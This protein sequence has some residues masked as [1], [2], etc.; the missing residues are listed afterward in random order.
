MTL[1]DV[2][3][4]VRRELEA[5]AKK[6]PDWPTDPLHALAVLG[7]EYGEL[8]KALLQLTY[9]PHKTTLD[10]ARAEAVQTAAMAL[11]LIQ[12]LD[13]YEFK[14][15][16][17]HRQTQRRISFLRGNHTGKS[18]ASLDEAIDWFTNAKELEY[19]VHGIEMLSV[20]GE[21]AHRPPSLTDDEFTLCAIAFFEKHRDVQA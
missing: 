14:P 4:R 13:Q 20:D 19:D 17:Q 9:E 8:N 2:I 6:Y 18:F 10:E 16:P 7:E 21:N 11:R 1:D 15:S 5:A 3:Y 12:S